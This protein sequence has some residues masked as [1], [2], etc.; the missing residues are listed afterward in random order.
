MLWEHSAVGM[1]DVVYDVVGTQCCGIM[2]VGMMLWE[3]S[4]VGYCG[5]VCTILWEH[6]AVGCT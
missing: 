4:V 3:H 2:A 6:S 1:Y 5:N